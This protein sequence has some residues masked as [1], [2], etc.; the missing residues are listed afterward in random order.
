MM[1]GIRFALVL[2]LVGSF[3]LCDVSRGADPRKAGPYPVG[4]RTEVFVDAGRTCAVTGKPRTLVTEIWYPATA[5]AKKKPLNTFSDYFVR[6][7][8]VQAATMTRL[9]PLSR[10]VLDICSA[11]SVLQMKSPSSAWVTFW[12]LEQ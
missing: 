1:K 10:M 12:R 9:S 8:G 3:V 11:A 5:D 7:A 4:V 6:P 2:G